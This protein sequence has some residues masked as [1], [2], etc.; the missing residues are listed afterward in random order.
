MVDCFGCLV[1]EQDRREGFGCLSR[2]KGR[3]ISFVLVQRM[4]YLGHLLMVSEEFGRLQGFNLSWS[5]LGSVLNEV[6]WC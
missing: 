2:G 3:D 4:F 6:V 5:C 1:L